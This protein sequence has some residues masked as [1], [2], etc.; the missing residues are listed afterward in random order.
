MK[1]FHAD[2]TAGTRS[3]LRRPALPLQPPRVPLSPLTKQLSRPSLLCHTEQ[4][5]PSHGSRASSGERRPG[6]PRL[7]LAH[8]ARCAGEMEQRSSGG[9]LQ[10]PPS[11]LNPQNIII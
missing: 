3:S 1:R 4:R 9:N 8:T 7:C 6:Q 5:R 10:K 2:T 11:C